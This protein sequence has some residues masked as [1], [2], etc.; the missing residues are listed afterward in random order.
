MQGLRPNDMDV[1]AKNPDD[2]VDAG[3]QGM[4]VTLTVVV[5]AAFRQHCSQHTKLLRK[6]TIRK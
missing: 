2:G 1:V 3:Q 4:P 5:K 6:P